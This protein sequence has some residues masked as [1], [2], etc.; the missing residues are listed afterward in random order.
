MG[1]AR[2]GVCREL[3]IVGMVEQRGFTTMA[4]ITMKNV[5]YYMDLYNN[6]IIECGMNCETFYWP[7]VFISSGNG[8][9]NICH[10][11]DGEV[12]AG[13]LSTRETY[14]VMHAMFNSLDIFCRTLM[15]F[16]K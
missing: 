8:V 10:Q 7:M 3:D 4:R 15:Y 5:H 9:H 13:G 1:A 6:T 14:E 12:I 2:F 16:K 11:V